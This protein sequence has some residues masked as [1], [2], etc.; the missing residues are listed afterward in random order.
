MT[1]SSCQMAVPAPQDD[2][3]SNQLRDVMTV[4][5]IATLGSILDSQLI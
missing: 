2:R 1:P 3:D 4:R 5:N